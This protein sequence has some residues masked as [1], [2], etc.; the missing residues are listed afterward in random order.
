[1]RRTEQQQGLRI[2]KRRDVMSRSGAGRLRQIEAVEILGMSERPFRRC[3]RLYEGAGEDGV[4]DRRLGRASGRAVGAAERARI[5][6]L[7]SAREQ[8]FTAKHFHER[9]VA[10]HGFRWGYTWTKLV[11]P[12][13]SADTVGAMLAGKAAGQK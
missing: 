9:L 4:L 13:V 8:G 5:E 10:D 3:T 12:V 1:M 11:R 7:Y 6:G 2:L